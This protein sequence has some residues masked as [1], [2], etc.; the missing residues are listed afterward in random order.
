ML[1]SMEG[2]LR[3]LADTGLVPRCQFKAPRLGSLAKM[4]GRRA[5]SARKLP[6]A[7]DL[8]AL[9]E[10]AKSATRRQNEQRAIDWISKAPRCNVSDILDLLVRKQE[11]IEF[12]SSSP[13]RNMVPV[14][15]SLSRVQ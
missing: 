5:D 4:E 7:N 8:S 9:D 13:P 15:L 1:I 14:S 2:V 12:W 10:F 11:N 6:G 3:G